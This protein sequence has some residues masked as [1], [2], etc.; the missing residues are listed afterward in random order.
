M[1][2]IIKKFF[3]LLVNLYLLP[4][5]ILAKLF[6][7]IKKLIKRNDPMMGV[8]APP[9]ATT[10][11]F[12]FLVASILWVVIGYV[13]FKNEIQKNQIV[14]ACPAHFGAMCTYAQVQYQNICNKSG[15]TRFYTKLILNKKD[16][17]TFIYCEDTTKTMKTCYGEG[18]G[19][20]WTLEFT[21][22]N[23]VQK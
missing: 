4:Y 12:P 19:G 9:Q 5:L 17:I 21:G 6:S 7:L 11:A 23:V 18:D 22:E 1:I 13:F 16:T 15:C 10:N 20:V 3:N 2:G 8:Q 14:Y